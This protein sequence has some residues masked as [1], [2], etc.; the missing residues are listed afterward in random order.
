MRLI[1]VLVP[2]KQAFTTTSN[3]GKTLESIL[4]Y[5]GIPKCTWDVRK[6]ADTLWA[7]YQVGLAGVTDIKLGNASRA[8]DK[9]HARGLTGVYPGSSV[10]FLKPVDDP[11]YDC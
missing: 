9:T 1:V 10:I 8:G 5:A 3:N 11:F 2:G 6:D 7:L 4:K